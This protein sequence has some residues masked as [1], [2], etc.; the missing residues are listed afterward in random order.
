MLD[1]ASYHTSLQCVNG[2]PAG[3]PRLDPPFVFDQLRRA[4]VIF[5]ALT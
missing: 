5:I 2:R 1:H 4:G 3:G